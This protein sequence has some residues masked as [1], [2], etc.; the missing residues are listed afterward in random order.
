MHGGTRSEGRSSGGS[1]LL[2]GTSVMV[3]VTSQCRSSSKGLLA[4]GI[5]TFV[6]S[7]SR[8]NASVSGERAGV[9]ERL[10]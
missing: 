3:L 10:M 1:R 4:V 7:L 5:G 2:D 9:A 6:R 8:V